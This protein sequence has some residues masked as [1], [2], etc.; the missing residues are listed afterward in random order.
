MMLD[1]SEQDRIGDYL[2]SC[3]PR[4]SPNPAQ[5]RGQSG[6]PLGQVLLVFSFIGEWHRLV[7]V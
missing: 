2:V 6:R 4:S 3:Q 5:D 1:L 7:T